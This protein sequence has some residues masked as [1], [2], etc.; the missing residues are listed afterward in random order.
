M[1][2]N[3]ITVIILALV[4]ANLILTAILT[5]TLL[6]QAKKSN[7]LIDRICSAIDLELEA[8]EEEAAPQVSIENLEM[9]DLTDSFT[10]TLKSG[11]TESSESSENNGKDKKHYAIFS[12]GISLDKKSKGYKTYGGIEGLREKETM[13]CD[14]IISVVGGYTL[15]EFNADSQAAVKKDIL[16]RLQEL[17]GS[18]LIIE[19]RFKSVVTE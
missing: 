7:E 17:F 16:K 5:F 15:E 4:L 13:I 14:E 1:K 3:L 18:D 19:V 11:Q 12:V 6:P 9:F 2:K 8:G 10:V